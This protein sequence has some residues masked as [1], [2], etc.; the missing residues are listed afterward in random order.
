MRIFRSL[1][2]SFYLSLAHHYIT[3][4]SL[5]VAAR[6][7]PPARP[8]ARDGR[9]AHLRGARVAKARGESRWERVFFWSATATEARVHGPK[10]MD[11]QLWRSAPERK[12]ISSCDEG[13]LS[14]HPWAAFDFLENLTIFRVTYSGRIFEKRT[15]CRTLKYFWYILAKFLT[16]WRITYN[17]FIHIIQVS[18]NLNWWILSCDCFYN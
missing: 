10:L 9:A 13:E 14:T 7:P 11:R 1:F 16:H 3:S 2:L 15:F 4:S 5:W 12:G 18:L 17:H 8:P 6:R